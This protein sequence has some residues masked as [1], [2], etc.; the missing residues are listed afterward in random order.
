MLDKS[1]IG[2]CRIWG[3]FWSTRQ[4]TDNKSTIIIVK[5]PSTILRLICL[6]QHEITD[7]RSRASFCIKIF[8]LA[9]NLPLFTSTF[10]QLLWEFVIE[11]WQWHLIHWIFTPRSYFGLSLIWKIE[12]CRW[13]QYMR[14]LLKILL[15]ILTSYFLIL[16]KF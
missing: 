11:L 14:L 6:S 15:L 7:R 2:N 4:I 5:I 3:L 13:R 9:I 10:L 12:N 16:R 8:R 1:F